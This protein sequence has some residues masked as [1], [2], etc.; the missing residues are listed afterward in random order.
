MNYVRSVLGLPLR[1]EDE[2]PDEVIRPAALPLTGQGAAQPPAPGQGNTN[3]DKGGSAETDST[4][5]TKN[6][7]QR[8]VLVLEE[9]SKEKMKVLVL[10][11]ARARSKLPTLNCFAARMVEDG[12]PGPIGLTGQSG[13]KR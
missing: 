7:E 3:A 9:A 6:S 12:A 2:K 10:E 13:D 11:E 5:S 1:D 8:M 4:G